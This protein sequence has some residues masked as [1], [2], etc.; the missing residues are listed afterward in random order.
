[1]SAEAD[2]ALVVHGD[3]LGNPAVLIEIRNDLIA[4]PDGVETWT[5][6]IERALRAIEPLS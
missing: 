6:K 2:Y 4:D 1:V 5:G 3:Q